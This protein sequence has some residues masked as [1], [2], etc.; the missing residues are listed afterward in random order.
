MWSLLPWLQER[1]TSETGAEASVLVRCL[2]L[3]N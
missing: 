2:L 1:L 3:L